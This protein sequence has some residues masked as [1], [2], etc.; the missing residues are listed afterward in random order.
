VSL[1]CRYL[2]AAAVAVAVGVGVVVSVGLLST[3]DGGPDLPPV[4]AATTAAEA[5]AR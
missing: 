4:V 3:G 2:P 1:Y 5:A